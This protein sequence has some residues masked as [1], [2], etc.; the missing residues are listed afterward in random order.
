MA[1]KHYGTST[2]KAFTTADYTKCTKASYVAPAPDWIQVAKNNNGDVWNY[3]T[4]G[5]GTTGTNLIK[6]VGNPFTWGDD[7][8]QT[9]AAYC[10]NIVGLGWIPSYTPFSLHAFQDFGVAAGDRITI[11][12]TSTIVMTKKIDASGV[13]FSSVGVKERSETTELQQQQ[14]VYQSPQEWFDQ[15]VQNSDGAFDTASITLKGK[16]SYNEPCEIYLGY[17]ND[18]GRSELSLYTETSRYQDTGLFLPTGLYFTDYDSVQDKK[19]QLDAGPTS[20]A[21]KSGTQNNLYNELTISKDCIW[22][23]N[24]TSGSQWYLRTNGNGPVGFCG[25]G[26]YAGFGSS[27]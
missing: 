16:N 6:I 4:S 11:D 18:D 9:A 27:M 2:V 1:I 5:V 22:G 12:G 17:D 20:I 7:Y 15:G 21:F 24:S 13:T 8:T 25:C 26:T 19:N 3:T 23:Y 10:F 14:I